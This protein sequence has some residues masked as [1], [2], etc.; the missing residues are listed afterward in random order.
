MWAGDGKCDQRVY[1]GDSRI[2][3]I[4][5]FTSLSFNIVTKETDSQST[6]AITMQ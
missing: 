5:Y 4:G 3:I 6:L 2:L 1:T